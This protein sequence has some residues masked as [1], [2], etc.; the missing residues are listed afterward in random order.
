MLGHISSPHPPHVPP[1]TAESLNFNFNR[2]AEGEGGWKTEDGWSKS[3]SHQFRFPPTHVPQSQGFNRSQ[4]Q[5]KVKIERM[6]DMRPQ[7]PTIPGPQRHRPSLSSGIQRSQAFLTM[8]SRSGG[9]PRRTRASSRIWNWSFRA[10]WGRPPPGVP[11]PSGLPVSI[12]T[13]ALPPETFCRRI[14][15]ED[16]CSINRRIS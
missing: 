5:I 14:Q 6:E 15:A 16:S 12:P 7:S 1:S 11:E 9:W 13:G 4:G 10:R 8:S 3:P 2:G